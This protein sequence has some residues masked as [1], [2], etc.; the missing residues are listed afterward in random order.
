MLQFRDYQMTAINAIFDYFAK[1]GRGN[2]LCLMPTGTGKSVVIAGCLYFALNQYPQTRAVVATHVKELVEQN[3]KKITQLWKAAPAGICSA[4]LKRYETHYP[5][6]F[7]G[8]DTMINRVKE[9]GRVD[10]LFIDEA[11]LVGDKEDATYLR[12]INLLLAVNPAMKVIGFTATGWRSKIGLLTNGPIFTD[13]A[14]DMTTLDWFRWFVDN[15]YLARLIVP[16]QGIQ[17]QLDGIKTVNGDFKQSEVESAAFKITDAALENSL[18]YADFRKKWLTFASGVEHAEYIAKW[19]NERGIK[20]GIVHSKMPSSQ[21]DDTIA[22]LKE[23]RLHNVTNYGVLTTGFDAPDIDLVLMLRATR[24]SQLWVQMLGRGTRPAPGKENCLVL[25]HGRNAWRLGTIDDPVIPGKTVRRAG[26]APVK[27]C[28]AC[29]CLNHISAR[30]CDACGE[31]F[32]FQVQFKAMA[33]TAE[34]MRLE[35]PKPTVERFDVRNVYYT[36][37]ISKTKQLPHLKVTY[38]TTNNRVFHE[39]VHLETQGTARKKAAAWWEMHS[40]EPCPATV[41]EALNI[42]AS[43]AIPKTITVNLSEDYPRIIKYEYV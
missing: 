27:L 34:V 26:E 10:L 7:G 38:V 36:R 15:G 37:H 28:S 3:Y 4:G 17:M 5:I 13:V 42:V 8:I 32:E 41:H 30:N 40:R 29:G 39:Y 35:A 1:G 9:L 31:P 11:H 43:L 16:E 24:V 14:I 20:T 25:D 22:A 6:T 23:G 18:K 2:P 21:R 19:Y 12:F 33:G